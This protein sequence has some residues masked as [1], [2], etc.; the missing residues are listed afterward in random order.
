ML[1]KNAKKLEGTKELLG[2]NF[3]YKFDLFFKRK[4]EIDFHTIEDFFTQIDDLEIKK[5]SLLHRQMNLKVSENSP[6]HKFLDLLPKKE[7]KFFSIVKQINNKQE[8]EEFIQKNIKG[9]QKWLSTSIQRTKQ[10]LAIMRFNKRNVSTYLEYLS[11]LKYLI[12]DDEDDERPGDYTSETKGTLQIFGKVKEEL[13]ERLK[14]MKN[15][16]SFLNDEHDNF[17]LLERLNLE[18][19]DEAEM[20]RIGVKQEDFKDLESIQKIIK[21]L[22]QENLKADRGKDQKKKYINS[23]TQGL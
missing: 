4:M 20:E 22:K 2:S 11:H 18:E 10:Y 15:I 3:E 19:I 7:S 17:I 13:M 23:W 21:K 12:L 14:F 8:K 6:V 1:H 16:F 9:L 5:F